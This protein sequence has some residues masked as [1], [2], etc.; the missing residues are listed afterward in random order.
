MQSGAP[1]PPTRKQQ[2]LNLTLA[3]VVGQVGFLTLIII[4]AAVFGGLWLD[5]RLETGRTAT[6]LMVL[7][8]IPI[9]LLVMY[10]VSRTAIRHI[11]TSAETTDAQK[12]EEKGFGKDA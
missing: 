12:E 10:W 8:S 2:I 1:K 7:S 5:A 9:S 11:K 3:A 6:I 4:L